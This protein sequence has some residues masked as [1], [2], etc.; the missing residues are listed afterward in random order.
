MLCRRFKACSA[1]CPAQTV[2]KYLGIPTYDSPDRKVHALAK[3]YRPENGCFFKASVSSAPVR[4]A[5]KFGTTR[6]SV[7]VL[8]GKGWII[9]DT[10]SAV[11]LSNGVG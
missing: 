6:E 4:D 5:E 8:S 11:S 9:Y 3:M 2:S 1:F 10:T 7:S